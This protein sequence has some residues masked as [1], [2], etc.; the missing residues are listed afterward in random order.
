MKLSELLRFIIN[1]TMLP[2]LFASN[3]NKTTLFYMNSYYVP[4]FA[5]E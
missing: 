3:N 4:I 1:S 5:N 2:K